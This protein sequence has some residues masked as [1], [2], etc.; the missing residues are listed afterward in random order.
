MTKEQKVKKQEIIPVTIRSEAYYDI[1]ASFF[2][3]EIARLY[4]IV[5]KVY[6]EMTKSALAEAEWGKLPEE[7]VSYFRD[8]RV[9]TMKFHETML[10][11]RYEEEVIEKSKNHYISELLLQ[12]KLAKGLEELV[13][14]IDS[15]V[16]RAALAEEGDI[17]EELLLDFRDFEIASK[18]FRIEMSKLRDVKDHR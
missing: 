12:A 3:G 6:M 17:P 16:R 8:F 13:N 4:A 7:F 9:V 10:K 15:V 2:S 1:R 11:I 18:K 5:S 14:T